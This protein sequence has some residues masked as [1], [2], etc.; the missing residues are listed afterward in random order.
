MTTT[1]A[2]GPVPS[3]RLY[4]VP[5]CPY[6][7]K[8]RVTLREQLN[9]APV[10]V[11]DIPLNSA[12]NRALFARDDIFRQLWTAE[13]WVHDVLGGLNVVASAVDLHPESHMTDD[14]VVTL[15]A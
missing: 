3:M 7:R 12:K 8:I 9:H 1:S 2:G 4:H 6:C 5:L 15:R 10:V 11:F 14:L 13:E